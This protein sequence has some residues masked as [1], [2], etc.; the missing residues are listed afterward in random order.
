MPLI[1]D[2]SKAGINAQLLPTLQFRPALA[3]GASVG[4]RGSIAG[5]HAHRARARTPHSLVAEPWCMRVFRPGSH[6]VW[7]W[8]EIVWELL[9]FSTRIVRATFVQ[10]IRAAGSIGRQGFESIRLGIA[11]TNSGRRARAPHR[12][13]A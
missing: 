9:E 5:T 11:H 2:W 7:K 6:F 1:A 10:D 12:H 13:D 4:T 3:R 8:L